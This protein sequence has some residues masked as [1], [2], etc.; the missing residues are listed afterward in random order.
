MLKTLAINAKDQH[1]NRQ[2]ALPRFIP[3]TDT[4]QPQDQ[5]DPTTQ[6][7]GKS[8][9]QEASRSYH[10]MNKTRLIE[11]LADHV[12]RFNCS[13]YV[14]GRLMLFP[15]MPPAGNRREGTHGGQARKVK[16]GDWRIESLEASAPDYLTPLVGES[17]A[18]QNLLKGAV[19]RAAFEA[20][21]KTL[22]E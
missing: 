17:F 22:Y 10:P 3:R 6:E 16:K 4:S 13:V 8:Q 9:A 11:Q 5:A 1:E 12:E 21:F 14:D 20:E 19:R 18:G 7:A 15:E 2:A